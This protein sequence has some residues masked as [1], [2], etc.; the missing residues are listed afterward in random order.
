MTDIT[1]TPLTANELAARERAFIARGKL[2]NIIAEGRKNAGPIVERVLTEVPTDSVVKADA[3]LWEAPGKGVATMRFGDGPAQRMHTHALGQAAERAG[4]PHRYLVELLDGDDWQRQLA[5]TILSEHFGHDRARYLVRA[6]GGSVRGILSDKFRRLDSRPLLE[7]FITE[8][9]ALGLVPTGGAVS[10]VRVSLKT[11][12]PTVVES[13]RGRAGVFGLDWSNSDYGAGKL[14][15]RAYWLEL[16][17]LNGMVGED[18]LSTVHLGRRIADS[19]ELSVQTYQLDTA[20]MVSATR[21]VVR[22]AISDDSRARVLS[23]I[24]KADETVVSGD[25]IRTGRLANALTKTEQKRA[26]DLFEGP[27]VV[28][29]P[30][31]RTKW[32]LSNALSWMANEA[33]DPARRLELERLAG[34]AVGER[35]AKEAA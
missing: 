17:C 15:I 7:A 1:T 21:D 18:S 34:E 30:P 20:A 32:R 11:V 33:D 5:T 12:L 10:D 9:N 25:V 8:A 24:A 19:I 29:L 28:L 4:V 6:A 3:I 23:R 2:E 22:A 14:A 26:R 35:G 27:E 13:P 31:E 16:V